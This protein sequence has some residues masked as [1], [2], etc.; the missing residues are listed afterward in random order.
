VPILVLADLRL[1]RGWSVQFKYF[2][3]FRLIL[4]TQCPRV[5]T[6]AKYQD[7]VELFRQGPSEHGIHIFSAYNNVF[8]DAFRKDVLV[9]HSEKRNVEHKLKKTREKLPGYV[10]IASVEAVGL[11]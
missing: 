8:V 11:K 6:R 2:R 5:K 3:V 7:L 10:V 9:E 4:E 1:L